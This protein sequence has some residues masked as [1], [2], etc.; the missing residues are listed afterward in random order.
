MSGDT[1]GERAGPEEAAGACGMAVGAAPAQGPAVRGVL[2]SEGAPSLDEITADIAAD[3]G[4]D[5][6][7]SRDTVHRVITDGERLGR[8]A[9]VVAVATVLARRAAWDGPDLAGRTREL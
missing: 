1:G 9:D 8:Q 7:P 5:G 2:G 3:D 6:A 4:L